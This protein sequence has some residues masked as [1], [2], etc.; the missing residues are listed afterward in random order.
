MAEKNVSLDQ[1]LDLFGADLSLNHGAVVKVGI[2]PTLYCL[3]IFSWD[4]KSPYSFG[5]KDPPSKVWATADAIVGQVIAHRDREKETVLSVDW[6]PSSVYW[7][8]RKAYLVQQAFFMGLL[9]QKCAEHM[10]GVDFVPST[11]LRSW[12]GYSASIP[13]IQVQE[14][15]LEMYPLQEKEL[16]ELNEDHLDAYIVALY[17]Y[18]FWRE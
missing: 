14:T 6:S 15:A 8:G 5:M 1:N 2:E 4:T 3:P 10:I 16:A 11:K 17:T 12:L 7:S 18:N 13:K 9:Y